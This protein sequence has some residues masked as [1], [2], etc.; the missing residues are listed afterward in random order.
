MLIYVAETLGMEAGGSYERRGSVLSPTGF[1]DD[2]PIFSYF[3][4]IGSTVSDVVDGNGSTL[5]NKTKNQ[6]TVTVH[7]HRGNSETQYADTEVRK[8]C[9]Q[10]LKNNFCFSYS[11]H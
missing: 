7:R 4:N 10:L 3:G 6:P 2:H 9:F 5:E 8:F 11:K 1:Y